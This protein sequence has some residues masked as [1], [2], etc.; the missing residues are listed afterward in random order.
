MC[1][2]WVTWNLWMQIGSYRGLG[3][4][5]YDV[6]LYDQGLWL[7]SR[8]DA[9]FV[10]LMGRNLF[11]DHSSLILLPLVPLYWV[12]PGVPTLFVVQAL[13][14]AGGA[15]PTYLFARK[16]LRSDVLG[17]V[18]AAAWLCHPAVNGAALENFHPDSA[19][20]LTVPL[21]LWAAHEKRWR[22]L[23]LAVVLT[24]MVKEDAF[25]I[26][27]PLGI[28][29]ALSFDRRKGLW[30]MLAGLSA[31]II[32]MYGI[33]R[34]LTGVPTRNAWRVPFGGVG[35]FVAEVFT[36]PWNVVEYFLDDQ[37][38]SYL[39]QMF[40]PFLGLF[41]LSSALASVSLLVI[42]VNTL[43]TYWYQHDVDYHYSIVAVAPLLFAAIVGASRLRR[44][45]SRAIIAVGVASLFTMLLVSPHNLVFGDR[46]TLSAS[47]P[48][49]Q[50]GKELARQV[51]DGVVISVA[52]PVVTHLAHRREIYMFPNPFRTLLYGVDPAQEGRRLEAADRV[53]WVIVPRVRDQSMS[54]VWESERHAFDMVRANTYFELYR[55]R[56]DAALPTQP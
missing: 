36:A 26:V 7:L 44:V 55:R 9:P 35:G 52:D 47:H 20:G 11:G 39:V 30:T 38:V 5:A 25:L 28:W 17:T 4:F 13:V 41:M 19:Y 8:F 31:A 51:P 53:Q 23:A 10:T 42:F 29:I 12:V 24:L 45:T 54:Q 15:I 22:L 37:R 16:V 48:Y 43:S 33:M 14:I 50:A 32:T 18:A 49:V 40:V 46:L 6:G 3:T 1:G 34:P 2:V 21:A 56:G 27:V